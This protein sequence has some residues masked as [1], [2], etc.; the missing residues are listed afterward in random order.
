MI[1]I[2]KGVYEGKLPFDDDEIRERLYACTGCLSC[3]QQCNVYHHTHIFEIVRGAREEAVT[4]GL[5]KPEYMAIYYGLRG[6][7][8]VF[9][10]PKTKRGDWAKGLDIKNATKESVEVLYH[11]GCLLS[12]Q[13]E[14]WNYR[15]RHNADESRRGECRH[16]G[17]RGMLLRRAVV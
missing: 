4:Q 15:K 14:L 3:Q 10:E 1:A 16:H 6:E 2:A 8:N 13:E 17:R 7:D 5:M 12:F 9:G 11:A